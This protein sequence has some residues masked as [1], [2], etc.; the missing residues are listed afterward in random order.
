MHE[1]ARRHETSRR[2]RALRLTARRAARVLRWRRRATQP[3]ATPASSPARLGARVLGQRRHRGAEPAGSCST[4]RATR[5][6]KTSALTARAT[7]TSCP[8]DVSMIKLCCVRRPAQR[9]RATRAC[10]IPTPSSHQSR[11]RPATRPTAPPSTRRHPS[12]NLA[13]LLRRL[14][15][16]Y[17]ATTA[18]SARREHHHRYRAR[19]LA[20]VEGELLVGGA[21]QLEQPLALLAGRRPRPS[22]PASASRPQSKR[23]GW[24]RGCSTTPGS[25]SSRPSRPARRSYRP[26]AGRSAASRSSRPVF[27]PFEC[28]SRIGPLGGVTSTTPLLARNSS[29]TCWFLVATPTG[30]SATPSARRCPARRRRPCRPAWAGSAAPSA[31]SSR[32]ARRCSAPG[33]A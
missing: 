28:S 11:S 3:A 2:G 5:S 12:P 6:S 24:R 22:R 30:G 13:A 1:R 18:L 14:A 27:A 4:R 7:P 8:P 9:Q 33:A 29:M 10:R 16:I 26:P 17:D 25:S 32:P 15:A 31:V 19:R 23:P 21:V 20:L